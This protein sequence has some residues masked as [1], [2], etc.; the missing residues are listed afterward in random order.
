VHEE[1]ALLVQA[2]L[3]PMQALQA[4]MKLPAEFLGKLKT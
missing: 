1:L 3:S 4:A 2:A